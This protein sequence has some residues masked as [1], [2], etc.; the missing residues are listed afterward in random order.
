MH[1]VRRIEEAPHDRMTIVSS[2]NTAYALYIT[3]RKSHAFSDPYS[4]DPNNYRTFQ[5]AE[6]DIASWEFT[7]H[8][9]RR[10]LWLF[11]LLG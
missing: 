10:R 5:A 8:R 2:Y 1:H 6:P 3:M 4:V 9:V 7:L 11:G